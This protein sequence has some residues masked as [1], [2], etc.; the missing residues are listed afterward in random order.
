MNIA[1]FISKFYP[2]FS[3]VSQR[4][5]ELY[6]QIHSKRKIKVDVYCGGY[7]S[8]FSH[9]YKHK[10]F[11]IKKLNDFSN[12]KFKI[13]KI[14]FNI[15]N[16]IQIFFFIKKNKY[17]FVHI[18]GS[19]NITSSAI[20][21]ACLLDKPKI[22][23]LVTKK[24]SPYQL[25]PIIKFLY[26][27][28]FNFNTL[29]IAINNEILNN[30]K[31]NQIKNSIWVR[32][33]PIGK[34]YIYKNKFQLKKKKFKFKKKD[35]V[36]SQIGQFYESKNQIFLID[37]L[38]YLPENFKLILAGPL[39]K[40][41]INSKKDIEYF[42]RIKKKIKDYNLKKRIKL[43]DKF[44]DPVEILNITSISAMPNYNE[45]FGNPLIE[46]LGLGIP[47]IVNNDEKIF[48]KSI[49]KGFNGLSIK[50]NAKEWAKQIKNFDYNYSRKKISKDIHS[51]IDYSKH[52]KSY[53]EIFDYFSKINKKIN[54]NINK[55]LN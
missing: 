8:N 38:S 18:I 32:D 13:L 34:K 14:F 44:I 50:L 52:I 3:G 48:R 39:S 7:E 33:N 19:N 43:I 25:L 4:I 12:S 29:I 27:P 1:I 45:G 23:E 10:F 40:K 17:D 42:E 21:A 5:I 22:I 46:S 31:S 47:V 35:I 36:I 24:S 28:S 37:V 54:I 15:I 9:I 30:F 51:K 6:E 2:E 53:V 49:I 55:I 16:F 26:R 41:G 20:N 11:S